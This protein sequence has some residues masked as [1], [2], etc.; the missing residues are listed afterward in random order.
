MFIIKKWHN[1]LKISNYS[2]FTISEANQVPIRAI[3]DYIGQKENR[4][5]YRG[6]GTVYYINGR[7]NRIDEMQLHEYLQYSAKIPVILQFSDDGMEGQ[8]KG[9]LKRFYFSIKC[10]LCYYQTK[11]QYEGL[12]YSSNGKESTCNEGDQGLIPGSGRSS[13][14]GNGNPLQ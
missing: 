2:N 12:L 14:E 13:G 5:Y 10:T 4:G 11:P 6:G 9:K 7:I 1:A 8:R 3:K